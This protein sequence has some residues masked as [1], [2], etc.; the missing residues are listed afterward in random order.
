MAKRTFVATGSTV[1]AGCRMGRFRAPLTPLPE[2]RP[3]VNSPLG[4][5]TLSQPD[6]SHDATAEKQNATRHCNVESCL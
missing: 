1:L 5:W 6:A 4:F 3:L 2:S